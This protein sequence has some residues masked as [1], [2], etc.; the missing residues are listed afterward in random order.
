[1]SLGPIMFDLEGPEL[2]PEE[3]D[4]LSHPLAGGIIL[5]SRN[6]RNPEQLSTL[7]RDIHGVREPQP[8]VA[9]DQEE[10]QNAGG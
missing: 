5:F 7:V 1:M 8:L 10:V 3:R 2:L 4:L 6:Y 9:V